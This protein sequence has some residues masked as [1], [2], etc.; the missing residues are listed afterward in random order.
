MLD[1]VSESLDCEPTAFLQQYEDA[2]G[3]DVDAV[4]EEVENLQMSSQ[5]V[6][7]KNKR[8]SRHAAAEQMEVDDDSD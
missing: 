2:Y 1:A 5:T 4:G 6:P 3:D 8:R 7:K